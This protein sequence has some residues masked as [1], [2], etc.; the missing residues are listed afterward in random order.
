MNKRTWFGLVVLAVSA[1][2]FLA[3]GGINSNVSDSASFNVFDVGRMHNE[4]LEQSVHVFKNI[5]YVP[6]DQR[7]DQLQQA[8]KAGKDYLYENYSLPDPCNCP[9][10]N[11]VKQVMGQFHDIESVLSY[12]GRQVSSA[13][14]DVYLSRLAAILTDTSSTDL[15]TDHLK[16]LFEEVVQI[17]WEGSDEVV[18]LAIGIAY[19]SS[20]YWEEYISEEGGKVTTT[21]SAGS[22]F[23]RQ[24]QDNLQAAKQ[25]IRDAD[26]GGAVGG[27][28]GTG[29]NLGGAVGVGACASAAVYALAVYDGDIPPPTIDDSN[30]WP[31]PGYNQYC[32]QNY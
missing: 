20:M 19:H 15:G 25:R 10:D 1:S 27:Y 31:E 29:G 32:W 12:S 24:V 28:F 4:A 30:P 3:C 22:S 26:V 11:R 8:L 9:E 2:Q 18:P 16:T 6:V 21:A 17:Q 7:V 5:G 23:D 13:T 14:A